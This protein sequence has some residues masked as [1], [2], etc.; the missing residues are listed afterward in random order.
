M[1]CGL[2]GVARRRSVPSDASAARL[3]GETVPLVE[4]VLTVAKAGT[5]SDVRRLGRIDVG[6]G[7]TVRLLARLRLIGDGG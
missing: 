7:T 2:D 5:A 3:G 4:C 1:V 6:S